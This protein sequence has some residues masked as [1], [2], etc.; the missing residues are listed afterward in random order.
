MVANFTGRKLPVCDRNAELS[1]GCGLFNGEEY[2][3][4]AEKPGSEEETMFRK[5]PAPEI[6]EL[7]SMIRQYAKDKGI[8]QRQAYSEMAAK[9]P[10]RFE[11]AGRAVVGLKIRPVEVGRGESRQ[12]IYDFTTDPAVVIAERAKEIAASE[13][14]PFR[15]ALSEAGKRDPELLRRYHESVLYHEG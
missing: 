15:A 5:G 9:Y 7:A 13:N 6:F 12:T 4:R 11:R 3:L 1:L 2:C 14:I 8:P 10:E